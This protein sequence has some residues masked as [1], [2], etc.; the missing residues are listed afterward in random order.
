MLNGDGLNV[1]GNDRDDID[2]VDVGHPVRGVRQANGVLSL[3]QLDGDS[4][5]AHLLPTTAIGRERRCLLAVHAD[6]DIAVLA[7][8]KGYRQPILSTVETVD[9]APLQAIRLA[10]SEP[11]R[12][13]ATRAV[14]GSLVDARLLCL[15]VLDFLIGA[16]VARLRLVALALQSCLSLSDVDSRAVSG[17]RH[18]VA[19]GHL[20]QVAFQE[21]VAQLHR[22]AEVEVGKVHLHLL[23][24]IAGIVH[25]ESTLRA[26]AL[27]EVLHQ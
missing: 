14:V 3:L 13:V 25:R 19:V 23:L 27:L 16:D 2:V 17:H 18:L 10:M 26:V 11:T 20:A 1:G 7:G 4:L 8:D 5:R 24:L 6:G 12:L 15:V 22:T 21:H 9:V